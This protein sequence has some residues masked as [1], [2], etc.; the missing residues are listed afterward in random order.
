MFSKV[1]A[2]FSFAEITN[3]IET[4]LAHFKKELALLTK[5]EIHKVDF[6]SVDFE[7]KMGKRQKSREK[8]K[9]L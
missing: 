4:L 5:L 2:I 9:N 1:S 6:I 7:R 8:E 3:R